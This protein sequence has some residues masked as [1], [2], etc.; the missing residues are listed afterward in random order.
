VFFNCKKNQ[1]GDVPT[2]GFYTFSPTLSSAIDICSLTFLLYY[3]CYKKRWRSNDG[4]S[5]KFRI[6]F[7]VV[8]YVLAVIDLFIC[9]FFET[10]PFIT[11]FTRPLVIL[12]FMSSS[13]A[14]L[15]QVLKLIQDSAILLLSIFVFVASYSFIG[16]F[17]FKNSMEGYTFMATPGQAFYSM[18]ICLTT[19]NYPNVMLPAYYDS[20]WY[21]LF[22]L[23]FMFLG[24][25]FLL[26]LLLA[27]IFENY[28]TRVKEK[29]E[30]TISKR[31]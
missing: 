16:F 9:Y 19:S 2:S 15:W 12:I 8:L 21:C 18:F 30:S 20:Y 25:Y 1:T 17:I 10:A 7:M 14:H 3:I 28:Q 26:N 4:W 31:G 11:N 5:S 6:R 24:L 23:S 13:R 27:T 22:F 29:F